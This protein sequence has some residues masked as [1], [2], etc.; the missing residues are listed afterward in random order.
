MIQTNPAAVFN[1]GPLRFQLTVTT[2]LNTEPTMQ[3]RTKGLSGPCYRSNRTYQYNPEPGSFSSLGYCSNR[4][5]N[6]TQNQCASLVLSAHE[7]LHG[8]AGGGLLRPDGLLPG[9]L[10]PPHRRPAPGAGR[11]A[12][13][14]LHLRP[15][16]LRGLLHPLP[17]GRTPMPFVTIATGLGTD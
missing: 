5:I 12:P 3:P 13:R 6:T 11:P 2:G 8:S 10:L 16:G 17:T 14:L 7:F 1:Q 9:S 4:I 15:G